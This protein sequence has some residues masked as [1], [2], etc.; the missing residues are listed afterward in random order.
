MMKIDQRL[1]E[2]AQDLG[3]N[4][5]VVFRKIIFPLTVPGVISGITMVFV[6]CVTS[7]I[8]P[9]LLNNNAWTI[10]K[11]IEYKFVSSASA[12]SVSPDGSAISFFLM[13]L[14]FLCMSI[15]NL[16][17]KDNEEGGTML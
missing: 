14:V 15:F 11:L 5:M 2:A 6:P 10:G 9:Q 17:D 3:G 7:F 4:N 13:L 16:M 1:I 8:I 12:E